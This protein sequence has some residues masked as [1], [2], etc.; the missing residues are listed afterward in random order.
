MKQ[1][2]WYWHL[3]QQQMNRDNMIEA[4][5][6]FDPTKVTRSALKMQ[7]ASAALL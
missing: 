5:D 3:M 1:V 4:R 7:P 6:L 2:N